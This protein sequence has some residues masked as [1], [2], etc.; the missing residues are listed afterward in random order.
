MMRSD[1]RPYKAASPQNYSNL[2]Y[3]CSGISPLQLPCCTVA[4]CPHLDGCDKCCQ[5][6][7][8]VASHFAGIP[9]LSLGD[10]AGGFIGAWSKQVQ[11]PCP[12]QPRQHRPCPR[13]SYRQASPPAFTLACRVHKSRRMSALLCNRCHR[14]MLSIPSDA[15]QIDAHRNT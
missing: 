1:A 9:D 3:N 13:L 5:P 10:A 7:T 8:A 2:S 6:L 15:C 4:P 12:G 14:Q 11:P